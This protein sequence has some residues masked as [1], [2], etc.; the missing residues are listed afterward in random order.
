M[1]K[2]FA[3]AWCKNR[4]KRVRR[5]CALASKFFGH[6]RILEYLEAAAKKREIEQEMEHIAELAENEAERKRKRAEKFIQNGN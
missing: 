3:G 1:P 5:Q 2:S 6:Q 4:T